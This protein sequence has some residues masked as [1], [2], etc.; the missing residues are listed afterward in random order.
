[1]QRRTVLA[2]AITSGLLL[3]VAPAFGSVRSRQ[4]VVIA[5]RGAS[6]YRPEHSEA[7]YRLAVRMGADYVEPDLVMTKDGVL[8][9]RHENE[10]GLTTDVADRPEFADRMTT[11][12]ISSF[13][14]LG[15]FTEDFTLAELKTLRTRERNPELRQGSAQ[16]DGQQPILTLQEIIDIVRMEGQGRATPVG[17]YIELKDPDYHR[18]IGLPIEDTLLA[19]LQANGLAGA[20]APVIVQSFWPSALAT[21]RATTSIKLCFLLNSV[22]P[23]EEILRANGITRYE[24]VYSPEGLRRIAGFADILGP[25]T[26]L[27]LP[28]DGDDRT[29][30]PTSLVADAHQAGLGVHVWS[31][32]AENA[33]LPSD[34]RLGDPSREGFLQELGD[35][36]RLAKRLFDLG[37]DGIFTDHPDLVAAAKPAK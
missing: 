9:A 4:P 3:A 2:G 15:W 11:K 31:V 20:D 29:G 7:A 23:P 24:D 5:H 19:V 6:G 34:Y 22:A 8:V 1:M 26:G 13:D 14:F 30:A 16:Y 21:L 25:E 28:R 17:L 37:V 36:T 33:H 35:A 10:L 18:Q 27:I 12:T 32:N